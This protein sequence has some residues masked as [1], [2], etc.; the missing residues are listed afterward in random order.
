MANCSSR[1][2]R[3][4]WKIF[5]KTEVRAIVESW[6]NQLDPQICESGRGL[7]YTKCEGIPVFWVESYY[8]GSQETYVLMV[9]SSG[10]YMSGPGVELLEHFFRVFLLAQAW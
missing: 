6:Q 4:L 1:D 7:Q 5:P 8:K 9:V 2:A 10:S 3:I